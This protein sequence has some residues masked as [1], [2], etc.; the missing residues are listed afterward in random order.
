MKNTLEG[1]NS[2]LSDIKEHISDLEDR[3]REINQNGKKRNK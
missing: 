1:V 2:I 3:I